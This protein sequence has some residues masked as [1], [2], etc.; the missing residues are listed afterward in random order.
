MAVNLRLVKDIFSDA[1]TIAASSEARPATNLQNSRRGRAWRSADTAAQALTG[2]FTDT[3]SIGALVLWR[4]NLTT[5]A[6]YRLRLWDAVDQGGTLVY[7]SGA[8]VAVEPKS[9]GALEWGIEP[10]GAS[11]FTGWALA[12]TA[13]WFDLVNARSWQLDLTD[14]SNADGYMQMARVALGPYLTAAINFSWGLQLEWQDESDQERTDGGSISVVERTPNRR[15][16]LDLAHV[17]PIER[18]KLL[19]MGRAQGRSKDIFVS[20]YPLTG[21][22]EERDHSFMAK[23]ENSIAMQRPN[24]QFYTLPLTFLEA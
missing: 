1:G 20:A 18:P 17:Q 5:D 8:Q 2:N 22:A 11:A 15:M 4:H 13:H 9:L 23:L 19:D 21:G 14:A 16:T 7:D 24:S 3:V 12:F 10:L 6:T